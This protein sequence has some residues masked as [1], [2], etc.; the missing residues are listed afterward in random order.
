MERQEGSKKSAIGY[1]VVERKEQENIKK[2]VIDETKIYTQYR[3]IKEKGMAR[4]IT[5]YHNA[6]ICEVEWKTQD[7]ENIG[8]KEKIS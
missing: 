8:H 5:T 1:I 7:E 3:I 2:M 4:E 6:M